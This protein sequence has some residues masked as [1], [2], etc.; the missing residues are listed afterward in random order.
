MAGTIFIDEETVYFNE[1]FFP[2]QTAAFAV[3]AIDYRTLIKNYHYVYQ[4]AGSDAEAMAAALKFME[5]GQPA[6]LSIHLQDTGEGGVASMRG[7]ADAPWKNDIWQPESPYRRN[8]AIADRLLGEFVQGL[9]KLGLLETTAFVVVGDHGQADTGWHPL[10]FWDPAVTTAV[11]WGAGIVPQAAIDYAELIDIGPTICALMG[12]SSPPTA[13][14]VAIGGA[15]AGGEAA[16]SPRPRLQETMNAQF[17]DFRTAK[18]ELDAYLVR[19]DSPAKGLNYARFNNITRNF[20]G[21]DRFIEWPRFKSVAEL[22]EQN[23]EALKS[24]REFKAE[25][26]P[27]KPK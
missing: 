18:A 27:A 9:A 23:G 1:Q 3:N 16:S 6:F 13:V 4:K 21:I 17:M 8:L 26:A 5:M 15:L 2:K 11:L 10:E 14:G 22:V 7:A 24:L 19:S 25:I 20:Y 12:V